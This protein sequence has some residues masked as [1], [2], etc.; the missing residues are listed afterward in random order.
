LQTPS[1][2]LDLTLRTGLQTP[3]NTRGRRFIAYNLFIINDHHHH[4][5]QSS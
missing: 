5:I 4:C 3:S 1:D 2:R